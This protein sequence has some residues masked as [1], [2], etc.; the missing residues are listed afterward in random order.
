MP[1]TIPEASPSV[2]S[3]IPHEFLQT[4]LLLAF[5]NYHVPVLRQTYSR[6]CAILD[7]SPA[8][9]WNCDVVYPL[10]AYGNFVDLSNDHTS[11]VPSKNS[12]TTL[13]ITTTELVVTDGDHVW[14]IFPYAVVRECRSGLLFVNWDMLSTLYPAKNAAVAVLLLGL[15]RPMPMSSPPSDEA[16]PWPFHLEGLDLRAVTDACIRPR[17]RRGA[18]LTLPN[19]K[20]RLLR[21]IVVYGSEL[22]VVNGNVYVRRENLW[23]LFV[24][25]TGTVYPPT[26]PPPPPFEAPTEGGPDLPPQPMPPMPPMPPIPPT[27]ESPQTPVGLVDAPCAGHTE[28]PIH[29]PVARHASEPMSPPPSLSPMS[30][31]WMRE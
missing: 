5:H 7:N 29:R 16:E 27:P 24:D 4:A 21:V 15:T 17:R 30:P 3:P 22:T 6:V 26:Q 2:T 9:V 23:K 28:S 11:F 10:P 31:V 18:D 13:S 8:C 14:Q 20:A 1:S 12:M 19:S 25:F